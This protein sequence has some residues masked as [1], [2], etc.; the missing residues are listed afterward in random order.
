MNCSTSLVLSVGAR[1]SALSRVQV[2]EVLEELNQMY[3]SVQFDPIWVQTVGDRD[4]KV[5]LRDLEKTDFFTREVDQLL[6]S[7]GC[8]IAIHSA[9]D[10]PDPLPRG[11]ALI[12]LTR[13]I[14]PS[15]VLAFRFG[16]DLSVL[17]L[18]AKIG[19]SSVRREGQV[20]L[21]RSDLV[22]V[23]IRGTI[24]AR[25]AQLDEGLVDGLVVA[26]AALIRLGLHTRPRL[27]LP[28]PSAP[29]QG[30]LAILSR[31]EDVEMRQLFSCLDCR[32]SPH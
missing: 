5:S 2:R 28:G 19:T 32:K 14:D 24:E 4:L 29:L 6:L 30:Q 27:V 10:L 1:G 21:L 15:D 8:R 26:E 9:K 22:C 25:L 16:E 31:E 23:D 18:K 13:G 12:A 11:L 20:R 7:G 3:P 17:P